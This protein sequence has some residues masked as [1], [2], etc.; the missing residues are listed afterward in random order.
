MQLLLGTKTCPR[1]RRRGIYMYSTRGMRQFHCYK[2]S[3]LYSYSIGG[4]DNFMF[5]STRTQSELRSLASSKCTSRVKMY[6]NYRDKYAWCLRVRIFRITSRRL[7]AHNTRRVTSRK[8]V[9][10]PCGTRT[11]VRDELPHAATYIRNKHASCTCHTRV[12]L[13]CTPYARRQ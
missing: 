13:Y 1:R 2:H 10:R 11:Y 3:L 7:R 8:V 9:K 4:R 12:S 6:S 5:N